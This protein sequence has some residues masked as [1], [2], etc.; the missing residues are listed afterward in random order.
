[1][2]YGI[3]YT[4]NINKNSCNIDMVGTQTDKHFSCRL[5]DKDNFLIIYDNSGDK[6]GILNKKKDRYYL[7]ITYYNEELDEV[8]MDFSQ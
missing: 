8:L 4:I 1:M 2:G 6:F 5:E 3:E 7:T